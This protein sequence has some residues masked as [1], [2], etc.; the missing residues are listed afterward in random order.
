L[1]GSDRLSSRCV[2][3]AFPVLL[4]DLRLWPKG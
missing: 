3:N 4:R 2:P 1:H